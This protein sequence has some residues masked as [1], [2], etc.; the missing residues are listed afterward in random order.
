MMWTLLRT[1][2]R[3]A[4]IRPRFRPAIVIRFKPF[5]LR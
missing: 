4:G 5:A 3:A 2:A 1:L